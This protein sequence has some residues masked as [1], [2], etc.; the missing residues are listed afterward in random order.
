MLSS[1]AA[2]VRRSHGPVLELRLNRPSRRNALTHALVE[3]LL[4]AV[5]EGMGDEQHRVILLSAEGLGFCAGK[6]RDDP[7]TDA[8]VHSLQ[9]LAAAMIRGPKPVIAAVQGWAV[10]AGFELALGCDLIVAGSDARFRLPE[11]QLGLPATGGVH[12]LLPRIAGI[13]RAKGL[14][15]LGQDLSATQA[16]QWG[17]AWEVVDAAALAD[18]ARS[19]AASL[20]R[21]APD[22]LARVK[23]LVHTEL[24]PD[25]P[26]ALEREAAA[27]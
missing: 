26:A 8:F 16:H 21:L 3:D 20:A 19:L 12:M 7:A 14:L 23:R 2:L 27:P 18:H 17:I 22:A 6:D 24:L 9:A 25:V 4:V 10:G 11:T 1:V 15:W 5:R 13:S